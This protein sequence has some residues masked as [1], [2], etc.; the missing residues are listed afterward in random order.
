MQ[1]SDGNVTDPMWETRQQVCCAM[2]PGT[3][4]TQAEMRAAAEAVKAVVSSFKHGKEMYN[5]D[6]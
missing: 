2:S 6:G 5:L 1:T 4:V 3:T